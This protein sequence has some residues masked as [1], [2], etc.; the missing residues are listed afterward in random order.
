MNIKLKPGSNIWPEKHEEINIKLILFFAVIISLLMI[1]LGVG[2]NAF[3]TP[4]FYSSK[5]LLQ[6][7]CLEKF[8]VTSDNFTKQQNITFS[9]GHIVNADF[10]IAQLIERLNDATAMHQRLTLLCLSTNGVQAAKDLSKLGTPAVEPLT[11][12]LNDPRPM[13]RGNAVLALGMIKNNKAVKSII[14]LINDKNPIVRM[15]TAMALS[16]IDNPD[17]TAAL[18]EALNDAEAEVRAEAVRALASRKGYKVRKALHAAQNDQ[19]WL[20]RSE[21]KAVLQ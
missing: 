19:S 1:T 3:F 4:K 17:V 11:L 20:V 18:I 14:A 10:K 8:N 21:I 6:N 2:N 12:A 9:D 16:S 7:I 13:V 5:G 15:K